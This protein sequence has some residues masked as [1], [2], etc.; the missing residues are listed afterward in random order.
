MNNKE[1]RE[2]KSNLLFR[3]FKILVE[4]TMPQGIKFEL[5]EGYNE[6][7]DIHG[8]KVNRIYPDGRE[9]EIDSSSSVEFLIDLFHHIKAIF[10]GGV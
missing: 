3:E 9:V 10:Q 2:R 4:D 5:W 8:F 1:Q 6:R 7:L